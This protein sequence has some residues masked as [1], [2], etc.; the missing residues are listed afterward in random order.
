MLATL[1]AP[2]RRSRGRIAGRRARGRPLA[3]EPDPA[4]VATGRATV[5]DTTRPLPDP[6]AAAAWLAG[7]GEPELADGLAVLNQVLRIHRVAATDLTTQTVAREA[8]LVARIGFG[9]GAEVADGRW[10]QARELELPDADRTRRRRMAPAHAR[11]AAILA[12]RD[13]LLACEELILRARADLD[14][15][16]PREAAL[17]LLVALDAAIAELGSGARAGELETR[18]G[19]LRSRRDGVAAA[20]Q[21]ALAGDPSA[22]QQ[23][24]VARTLTAV[25]AALRSRLASS[26]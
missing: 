19:D 8:C 17:Q 6:A 14:A 13:T 4:P 26:G 7:A 10:A 3:P 5:I 15:R 23:A 1:G 16:R 20:A 12:G 11:L 21:A 24:E 18:L 25:E 9:A 2:E 22:E